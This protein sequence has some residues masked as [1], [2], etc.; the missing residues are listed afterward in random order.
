MATDVVILN[1][2]G[3]SSVT[4]YLLICSAQSE[5][6]VEAIAREVED[7]LRK[8]GIRPLG[9]EG[10]NDGRW[11]LLDFND[12]VVHVFHEP[13]RKFYDLE[14]LWADAPRTEVKD[15]PAKKS[16]KA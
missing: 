5:R 7:G 4:D 1:L 14:G 9:I 16:N 10:V 12:V 15:K 8:E 3:Y 6:Q 13:I 11:A 2:K